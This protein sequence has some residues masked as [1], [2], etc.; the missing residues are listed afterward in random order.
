MFRRMNITYD[1]IDH[2]INIIDNNRA[3]FNIVSIGGNGGG[4]YGPAYLYDKIVQY[5]FEEVT[6]TRLDITYPRGNEYN[7]DKH[8]E[9]CVKLLMKLVTIIYNQNK[10]PIILI[11]WSMGGAIVIEATY[12]LQEKINIH[13][14]IMISSQTAR[15]E[16]LQ[17]INENIYKYFIHGKND[18][19]IVYNASVELYDIP[20]N[21][22]MKN[23]ILVDNAD[24]FFTD[25]EIELYSI[26]KNI[27]TKFTQ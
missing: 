17:N 12:R 6:F 16:N 13:G 22:L 3:K 10:K 1:N 23:I 15:T 21:K 9:H 11:G 14:L 25:F 7:R 19:C 5:P 4:L 2:E 18:E 26:V 27:I 8:F 20:T 24:H